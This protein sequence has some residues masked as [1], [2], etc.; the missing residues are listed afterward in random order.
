MSD[1][2]LIKREVIAGPDENGKYTIRETWD[3]KHP[4]CPIRVFKPPQR[5]PQPQPRQRQLGEPIM[6][7]DPTAEW[8][9][10]TNEGCPN[11]NP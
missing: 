5:E 7:V 2:G 11:P 6:Q 4:R 3:L 10:I 8:A 9:V 1:N